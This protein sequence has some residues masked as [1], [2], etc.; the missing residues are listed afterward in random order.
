MFL[1]WY[2]SITE[3][4]E[5]EQKNAVHETRS[6]SPTHLHLLFIPGM[7]LPVLFPVASVASV[8][9]VAPVV[10]V[11]LVAPVVPVA[12]VALVELL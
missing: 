5:K 6:H 12:S 10:P 4:Q 2:C 1:L 9:L 8:V 3:L 7:F 11:A